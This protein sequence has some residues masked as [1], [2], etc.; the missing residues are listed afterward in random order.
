MNLVGYITSFHGTKGEL[1]VLSNFSLKERVFIKNNKIIINK[2]EY[3]ITSVRKHK[4]FYLITINNLLELNKVNHLIKNDVYFNLE[5]L[6]LKDDEYIPENLIGYEVYDK[7]L[8]GKVIGI[9][10]TNHFNYIRVKQD[11]VFL[12]PM[13]DEY[14]K[15]VDKENNIIYT[16]N[17]SDLIL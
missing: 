13:I 7:T 9:E 12:I 5:L 17:G 6:K 11:K 14:I 8:I 3:T 1:K 10:K 15:K 16:I 2:E 4:N